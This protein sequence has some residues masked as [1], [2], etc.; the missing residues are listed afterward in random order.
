MS[1]G[2]CIVGSGVVGQA[3]GKVLSRQGFTVTFTDINPAVVAGLRQQGY[4]AYCVA[5]V[6]GPEAE[7]FMLSVP[8]YVSRSRNNGIE[9]IQM[10]SATVGKWL[11]KIGHYCLVVVRSAVLPGTTERVIIPLLEEHSGKK[12]GDDFGVCVNPEYLRERSAEQDFAHPWLVVIGELDRRS[13]DGLEEVY[14]WVDCPVY[15]ISLKEAEMQ[16]FVH[17]L[18]NATKISFFNEMRQVC[19]RIGVD[20]ERV[21][22][23]VARS[24][25]ALWNPE[26]GTKNLGPFGGSCLPKDLNAFLS[27]AREQGLETLMM[28]AVLRVNESLRNGRQPL[29]GRASLS[30]G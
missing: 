13:G 5:E 28:D 21:F 15:R 16:K 8:T 23:L 20:D 9:S 6:E 22:P 7:V 27:W 30:R 29:L 3:T 24:A 11:A 14:H 10:A 19:R 2:I 12:A 17:N 1:K 18:C 25:E 4:R 26:Y